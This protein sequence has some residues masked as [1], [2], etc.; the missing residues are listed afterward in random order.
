MALYCNGS[1]THTHKTARIEGRVNRIYAH[2]LTQWHAWLWAGRQ[3]NAHTH[4]DQSYVHLQSTNSPTHNFPPTHL[5]PFLA[6]SLSLSLALSRSLSLS[7]SL[8]L[9]SSYFFSHFPLIVCLCMCICLCT[10]LNA[11][12]NSSPHVVTVQS[13]DQFLCQHDRSLSSLCCF[14][15]NASDGIQWD[16][17]NF[18]NKSQRLTHR[19]LLKWLSVITRAGNTMCM[20][21]TCLSPPTNHPSLLLLTSILS[22]TSF[23]SPPPSF[24]LLFSLSSSFPF[25]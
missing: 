17:T 21:M 2:P 5:Y 14:Q 11:L 22:K 12:I 4:T 20:L 18:V 8:S 7:L 15:T 10:C 24:L 13:V 25:V 19:L 3:A 23:S 6:L 16:I 9:Y 1:S